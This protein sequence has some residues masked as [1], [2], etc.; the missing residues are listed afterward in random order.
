VERKTETTGTYARIA[1]TGTG[2]TTYT[3][4]G[5]VAGT[6]YCYRVMAVNAVGTS[7]YSNEA[8]GS[9]A[10]GFDVRV[11]TS[12][13]GSGTVVSTPAGITCPGT[14]VQTFAAGRMVTL[15]AAPAAGS[16]F[17][18]W[19]GSGCAGTAPCALVGNTPVSVTA[20]FSVVGAAQPAPGAVTLV[21]TGDPAT[22]AYAVEAQTSL[23]GKLTV[24]FFVD[25][26][27]FHQE[28]IAKYCLF[29]GDAA[30]GTGTLGA[31]A[32]VIT[33]QVLAQ[34]TTTVLAETQITVPAGPVALVVTGNP[35]SG[36]YAVEA[37]TTLTGPL[38]VN[39][40]VD[41]TFFHQED[42]AKYCLFGGDAAC[43][44]GTLGAGQHVIKV[45]VFP[46]DGRTV[47]ETQITVTE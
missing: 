3:D 31:G 9:P 41:G 45:Q 18:N 17:S 10:A 29:G 1:A 46:Q 21:V 39:F 2:I 47:A 34:G 40:F 37:Q 11:A 6:T 26:S 15:T 12:G 28:L 8:C 7:G 25:G 20:I 5:V 32:H 42:V 35:T 43:G 30:C 22:G 16:S 33:A 27:F 13:S 14:C 4:S 36:P 23:T 44:M 24:N 38:T 19:S